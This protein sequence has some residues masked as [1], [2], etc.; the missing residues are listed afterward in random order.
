MYLLLVLPGDKLVTLQPAMSNAQFDAWY[1]I[2]STASTTLPTLQ[3]GDD[4]GDGLEAAPASLLQQS[5]LSI[6]HQHSQSGS[7]Q[8]SQGSRQGSIVAGSH[9]PS[10]LTLQEEQEEAVQEQVAGELA[11][12]V[13]GIQTWPYPEQEPLD[14]LPRQLSTTHLQNTI[15]ARS[16][17]S[18]YV[19]Q[20]SQK[21]LE[22]LLQQELL[23]QLQQQW[24]Q[25]PE[26]GTR[27]I[28]GAGVGAQD[29][30]IEVE[31]VQRQ[32]EVSGDTEVEVMQDPAFEALQSALASPES[33][34]D[35]VHATKDFDASADDLKQL[36]VAPSESALVPVQTEVESELQAVAVPMHQRMQAALL[37]VYDAERAVDAAVMFRSRIK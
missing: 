6:K 4:S 25:Q 32:S 20:H 5:V 12:Q 13:S 31:D 33:A 24:Q 37:A 21:Q 11:L 18:Q 16:G 28:E 30:V 8:S 9:V 15:K 14:D 2:F 22:Q 17:L 23:K 29:G 36:G 27:E 1:R 3:D 19:E 10:H 34:N 7:E 35:P 26:L